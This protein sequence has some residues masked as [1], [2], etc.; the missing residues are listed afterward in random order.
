MKI[1]YIAIIYLLFIFSSL[2]SV[3]ANQWKISDLFDLKHWIEIQKLNNIKI[4]N[5]NFKNSYTRE[6]Y[7]KIKKYDNYLKKI[8][9]EKYRNNEFSKTKIN[10]IINN[11]SKFIY[12]TNSFFEH[13]ELIEKNP[14]LLDEEEF[15]L[16][17]I[18]IQKNMRTYYIHNRNAIFR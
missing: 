1:F 10:S 15:I 3:N 11:Y 6:I 9:E 4:N 17:I 13:L 18:Y 16:W 12:Y 8:I 5:F 14:S 7:Y 2:I